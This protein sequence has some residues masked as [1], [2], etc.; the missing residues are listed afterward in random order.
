LSSKSINDEGYLAITQFG[1]GAKCLITRTK[2]GVLT[3]ISQVGQTIV[4]RSELFAE[5]RSRLE[6]IENDEE[7]VKEI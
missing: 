5:F 7:D 6:T 2:F 1:V 3:E 4:T